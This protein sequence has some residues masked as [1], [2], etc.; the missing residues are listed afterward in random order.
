MADPIRK[1]MKY[2]AELFQTAQWSPRLA[3][4]DSAYS[5]QYNIYA[6]SVAPLIEDTA[7]YWITWGGYFDNP[8]G[9]GLQIYMGQFLSEVF[10]P[11]NLETTQN[12]FYI[13]EANNIC[14]M[15][16]PYNPWQYF[17]EYASVYGNFESTFATS[18]KDENN[19]S[20]IYY[21]ST[22]VDVRMDIPSLESALNDVISGVSTYDT[23]SIIIDNSDGYYDGINILSYFNTPLQISKAAND[24]VHISDFDRIRY[25]IVQDIKVEFGK[26]EIQA[27]DQL[28]TLSTDFCPKFTLTEFPNLDS[29]D[30][31][32]DIPVGWGVLEGIEPI[33]VDR[34]SADPCTWIDYIALDK[35]YITSVQKVYDSTGNELTHTFTAGTGIIR[36]TEVD[37][38]GNAIEAEYVNVTGKAACN[39]G[40]IITEALADN[41]NLSYIEGIW[42]V[43]ETDAYIALAPDTGTYF[44]GGTTRD[45]VVQ[46]LKN[47]M[48]YLIQK[49]DGRL[50]LRRW[51]ENYTNHQIES[52]T[53][54]Q[55]PRKNF[56][57]ATKYFCSSAKVNYNRF[58]KDDNYQANYL[59]DTNERIIFGKYRKSYLAN[60]DTELKSGTDAQSL[61]E[62]IMERFGEV[63]ETIE[64]PL[65]VN[66]F[67]INLLDT[68]DIEFMVGDP[69]RAFSEY[70]RWAV[71]KIDPGQDV[72]T[73][74]GLIIFYSL[75]FDGSG[76]SLDNV[77]WAIQE[78]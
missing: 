1:P 8:A 23:F 73:L 26:V 3:I 65:A 9:T 7:N 62:R 21:G 25:G 61:A 72:L 63:R 45:L 14:Y 41:E 53:I 71:K 13:D 32:E 50:T 51:G 64:V 56:A 77:R 18:P 68:V 20:D 40:E 36:V 69:A 48:A 78:D 35:S 70:S 2:I 33:E 22:K 4:A 67:D 44:D 6:F 43:T 24:P 10:L 29:G 57:D 28:Y 75:S 34:D 58:E 52:W 47:D 31:N 17:P 46:V 11:S 19:P 5:R 74:E 27:A 38:D 16:I 39:V 66:T 42:D 60:F 55:N 37:G 54:M 49:N 30:V 12:S 59:D 76:A 15:N